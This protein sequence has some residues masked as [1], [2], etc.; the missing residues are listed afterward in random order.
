[1]F[2]AATPLSVAREWETPGVEPAPVAYSFVKRT[3]DVVVALLLLP[4]I[5]PPLAVLALA[6]WLESGGP[7]LFRQRRTGL[8]GRTF[9]IYKLRSMYVTEDGDAIRHAT[10]G[11]KRVTR[12]GAFLRKSS[13]DEL[14]QLFNVLKGDMSLIGPRPHALSHDRHYSAFIPGYHNRFRT[15]PGLTGWAQVSGL[16]GEV[17]DI[18]HMSM[19]IAA[20][21]EY[22]ERWSV[23]M[24]V[25]I[26][27][28]TVPLILKASNA[29]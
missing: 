24:D 21:V 8:G 19:R 1:M 23:W 10:R 11:D 14:P 15:R 13:L 6:V 16:R 25:Q 20:D 28:R 12:V 29:Y 2:D 9:T 7:V 3:F 4:V 26:L 5:L 17:Y 27:V 18:E 22:I